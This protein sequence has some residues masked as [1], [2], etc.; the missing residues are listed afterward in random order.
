[1]NNGTVKIKKYIE[2][3]KY[4]LIIII[5]G[6]VLLC[7]Q[8]GKDADSET[9]K[10]D[11]NAFEI[12]DTSLLEEKLERVLGKIE[13]VGKVEVLLTLK[14]GTERIFAQNTEI[15]A[16]NGEILSSS[17]EIVT[18]SSSTSGSSPVVVKQLMPEYQGALVVCQG[19]GSA[20]IQMLV[21]QAVTALTG[22][23]SNSVQ[24]TKMS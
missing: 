3:Y 16:G 21:T 9:V 4:V 13:G 18:I 5:A 10:N 7:M 20:K 1:M 22:I 14:S 23:G 19:G 2:K 17:K 11:N 8:G 15:T 12:T 24:V 6:I